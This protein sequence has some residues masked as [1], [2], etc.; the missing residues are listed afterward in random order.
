M[1]KRFIVVTSVLFA[2]TGGAAAVSAQEWVNLGTREV[3]DRAE[4]DTWHVG[5]SHGQFRKIKITVQY[6]PVRFYKLQVKFEN[7]QTQ[8]IELRNVI[9]AGGETRAIDLVGTD[10]KIDKVDV[11]YE[12]QTFKRGVRSQVT[13]YGIR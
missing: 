1:L 2:L 3:K 7:G 9:R 6:K 11:W 8:D 12:A 4:Q 13:L 5:G 10:R